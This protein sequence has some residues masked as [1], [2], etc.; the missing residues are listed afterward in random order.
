MSASH[1]PD[2]RKIINHYIKQIESAVL[3][4]QVL[5]DRM[6]PF[7]QTENP[8]FDLFEYLSVIGL[9][10]TA[11]DL[12]ATVTDIREQRVIL[13][14][15]LSVEQKETILELMEELVDGMKELAVVETPLRSKA[16]SFAIKQIHHTNRR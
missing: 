5:C 16:H 1:H 6:T 11:D 13:V 10:R 14:G 15:L 9:L 12:T 2:V 8:E 4:L 3:N 7:T